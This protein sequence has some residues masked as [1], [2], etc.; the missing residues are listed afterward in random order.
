M[1]WSIREMDFRK[2]AKC[3]LS[4]SENINKSEKLRDT[5][6]KELAYAFKG[7]DQLLKDFIE[8]VETRTAS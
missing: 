6:V 1:A 2:K 5:D 7:I 4:H 8:T 3:T